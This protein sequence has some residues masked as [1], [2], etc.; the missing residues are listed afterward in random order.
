MGFRIHVPSSY[1]RW[2]RPFMNYAE[3]LGQV[4]RDLIQFDTR[5]APRS[6]APHVITTRLAVNEGMSPIAVAL[7]ATLLELD[8][9]GGLMKAWKRLARGQV[10]RQP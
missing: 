2:W 7:M 5:I 8:R 10:R 1:V 9:K 3:K 4:V 6:W